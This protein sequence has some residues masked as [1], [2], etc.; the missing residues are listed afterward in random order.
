MF[1]RGEVVKRGGSHSTVSAQMMYFPSRLQIEPFLTP[2]MP[3]HKVTEG[4]TSSRSHTDGSNDMMMCVGFSTFAN[5][6]S[7]VAS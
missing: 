6:C 5:H 1:E 7:K 3:P 2:P 4:N